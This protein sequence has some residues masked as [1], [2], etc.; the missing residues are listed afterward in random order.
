MMSSAIISN[1]IRMNVRTVNRLSFHLC[2]R[3]PNLNTTYPSKRQ[4]KNSTCNKNKTQI[5]LIKGDSNSL[6]SVRCISLRYQMGITKMKE[7]SSNVSR[8]QKEK[9]PLKNLHFIRQILQLVVV[10]VTALI[11]RVSMITI[12]NNSNNM[13][14]I[15]RIQSKQ[16]IRNQTIAS[17][18]NN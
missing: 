2:L 9:N 16:M 5:L 13:L 12:S 6:V 11:N 17:P 15:E 7:K 1:N 10:V 8:Q 3:Y 4:L 14:I 18:I